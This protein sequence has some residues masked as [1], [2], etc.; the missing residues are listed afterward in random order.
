M[1]LYFISAQQESTTTSSSNGAV[2]SSSYDYSYDYEIPNSG[3]A[4][5]AEE[6][7]EE[8][9]DEPRPTF[10]PQFTTEAQHFKVPEQHTIRLPCRVDRLGKK[11]LHFIKTETFSLCN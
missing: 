10:N 4:G 8:E 1:I 3:E 11:K 6:E 9:D 2:S 7:D 5:R